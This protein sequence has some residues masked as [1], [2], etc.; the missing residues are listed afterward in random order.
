MYQKAELHRV[1]VQKR[2]KPLEIFK[3]SFEMKK[4]FLY[5]I[6][7]MPMITMAQVDRTK[8]PAPSPAPPIQLGKPTAYTLPNGLK[9]FVVQNSKLPRVSASLTIDMDGIIE[10]DK[11]GITSMAGSLLRRGTAKMSKAQLDE[12]IDFLGASIN[13]SS[14][15]ASASSLKN[16][17][18]KVFALMSDVVLRPALPSAEL[19]KI[20]KNELSELQSNKDD[21]GAISDNVSNRLTFGKNHPYGDIATEKTIN[22]VK[23]DDIKKYFAT[24]WKPNNAYLVFVGAIAPEEARQLA[25]QYFGAWQKGVVP[26]PVYKTPQA[27]AKTFIALVDRPSSVQSNINFICPVELK[28]GAPDAIPASVMDNLLGGGSSGRLFQNLREKYGFTYGAYSSLNTDRL[29]GKFEANASVRNEK[30]DSAIGQFLYEFN[31]MRTESFT[32]T[33][34]NNMKSYLSGGFA[35]SLENPGTI[36]QFALN[37]AR[38]HLPADYYQ[39]YLRNLSNVN[40]DVVAEMAKKYIMP[41]RMVI[42]I[43]G[44]AKQIAPGLEKYGEVKYFDVY[45]NEVAA[46]VVKKVDASVT[47]ESIIQKAANATGSAEAMAAITDIDMNGEASLMGQSFSVNQKYVLPGTYLSAM[48][49]K[50]M[51][52]QSKML[53]D[54]KYTMSMQGQSQEGDEQDKEEIDEDAAFFTDAYMLKKGGYKFEMGT[55]EKVEGKDAYAVNI[56]TPTGREYTNYY[57]VA[58]GL[59]V[60]SSTVEDAGPAGKVTV[61]VYFGEYKTFNGIQ[62]PSKVLIDQGSLKIEMNFKDIKVNGGLKADDIK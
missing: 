61:Q 13:T 46:P 9:V 11:T 45:G 24:Y 49:M 58:N 41:G 27:S 32:E 39:N 28:P 6:A 31:K 12:E 33:E 8:A 23:L 62:V 48:S 59:K 7:L 25:V 37:I 30:T 50:G 10:G 20:R 17:F 1:K 57:D 22:N 35:R 38:Y 4:A 18:P 21:P 2:N 16:N 29:I 56:K 15:S 47:P 51:V 54:G 14:Q 55:I 34:V 40:T 3:K 52:L 44:N 26:K 53:K 42:V 19:E 36:A 5:I 43:V 60:K